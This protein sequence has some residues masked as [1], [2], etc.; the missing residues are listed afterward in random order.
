[1]STETVDVSIHSADITA[2]HRELEAVRDQLHFVMEARDRAEDSWNE[3]VTELD[4]SKAIQVGYDEQLAKLS[5]ERDELR[6]KLATALTELGV[7]RQERDEIWN[8]LKDA[9]QKIDE[10]REYERANLRNAEL[11]QRNV[12]LEQSIEDFTNST[13]WRITKPLRAVRR[14]LGGSLPE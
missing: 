2:L 1:M 8:W 13:S 11:T 14:M 6:E 5:R 3:V 9:N 4:K 10:L 12:Q 7:T